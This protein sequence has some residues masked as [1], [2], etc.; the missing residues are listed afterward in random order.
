MILMYR[1]KQLYLTKHGLTLT[2]YYL[3]RDLKEDQQPRTLVL[4]SGI[5]GNYYIGDRSPKF[6]QQ[7]LKSFTKKCCFNRVL[8][9]D[10][11]GYS[12]C[13]AHNQI[14]RQMS[15]DTLEVT[16][17]RFKELG[18]TLQNDPRYLALM[19]VLGTVSGFDAQVYENVVG[20]LNKCGFELGKITLLSAGFGGIAAQKISS[21]VFSKLP[22]ESIYLDP[23][24]NPLH[25]G[26]S[27]PSL[28]L[29][30]PCDSTTNLKSVF[31]IEDLPLARLKV[32]QA[33]KNY[34]N[35]PAHSD[36]PLSII[37][38]IERQEKTDNLYR[39][40]VTGHQNHG[41]VCDMFSCRS[42]EFLMGLIANLHS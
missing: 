1:T 25:R 4:I 24:L 7:T 10:N 21:N 13:M 26:H 35:Y 12:Y 23:V 41:A 17:K 19:Q 3:E 14:C 15:T 32:L 31:A 33:A 36:R 34:T 18:D 9:L 27:C 28:Y 42:L 16:Q 5:L 20:E 11:K 38:L 30:S 2:S 22:Y 39:V 40:V 8:M 6:I 37:Q 29:F